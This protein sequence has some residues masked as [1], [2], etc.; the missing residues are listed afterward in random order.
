M[1]PRSSGYEEME[2][3]F[4]LKQTVS[5]SY[6]YS[7]CKKMT[8]TQREWWNHVARFHG[9]VHHA[10]PISFKWHATF[11]VSGHPPASIYFPLL[12]KNIAS[13]KKG[14]HKLGQISAQ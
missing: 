3:E 9:L 6:T 7:L 1:A 12:L 8:S 4:G 2:T 14:C 10:A 5:R 13:I 11:H